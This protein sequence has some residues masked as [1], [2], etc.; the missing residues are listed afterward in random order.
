MPCLVNRAPILLY[1]LSAHTNL[2]PGTLAYLLPLS[3]FQDSQRASVRSSSASRTG[4]TPSV[5]NA[6]AP[7]KLATIHVIK[8]FIIIPFGFKNKRYYRFAT[9]IVTSNPKR[10]SVA[11]GLVHIIFLLVKIKLCK[12][13]M[14]E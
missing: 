3:F 5:A 12:Q 13:I 10:I 11:V 8:I 7:N 14:G 6:V 1:F 2:E 9:Y 4:V